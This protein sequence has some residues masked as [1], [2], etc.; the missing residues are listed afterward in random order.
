M[1]ID[2][3]CCMSTTEFSLPNSSRQ[4]TFSTAIVFGTMTDNGSHGVCPEI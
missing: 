1:D 3:S 2:G 4:N